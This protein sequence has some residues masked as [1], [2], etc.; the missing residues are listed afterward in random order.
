[1]LAGPRGVKLSSRGLGSMKHPWEQGTPL[2]L[3]PDTSE[4]VTQQM[5]TA[6]RV[7]LVKGP[8]S[9]LGGLEQQCR[10]D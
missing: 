8:Y 9:F 5:P 6:L 2:V 7:I 10:S 4:G 3:L 1:M